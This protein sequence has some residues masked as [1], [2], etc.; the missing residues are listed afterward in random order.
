MDR[1]RRRRRRR[2]AEQCTCCCC[3]PLLLPSACAGRASTLQTLQPS[4]LQRLPLL[5]ALA[6]EPTF[7]CPPGGRLQS[8]RSRRDCG[9]SRDTMAGS[10]VA[11]TR[12][13]RP[14]QTQPSSSSSSS[15][16]PQF[17]HQSRGLERPQIVPLPFLLDT[18]SACLHTPPAPGSRLPPQPMGASPLASR[19]QAQAARGSP[20]RA[21]HNGRAGRLCGASKPKVS[22]FAHHFL[23]L[24]V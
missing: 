12:Q 1:R 18:R 11:L 6:P 24:A 16:R 10:C 23:T 22:P 19:S 21:A 17:A 5:A 13:E 3:S 9:R 8:A 20:S 7:A 4:P 2:R 14:E 15:R